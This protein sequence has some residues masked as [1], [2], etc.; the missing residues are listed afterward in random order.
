ELGAWS[1]RQLVRVGVRSTNLFAAELF[2]DEVFGS[3]WPKFDRSVAGRGGRKKFRLHPMPRGRRADAQS[4]A[5]RA[6]VHGLP[7][8]ESGARVEKGTG[9]RS[10]EASGILE[11]IG[12]PAELE[13]LAE[14]RIG[15]VHPVHEPRRFA[16]GE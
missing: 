14:S 16:G 15:G 3:S 8:R 5:C 1:L 10:A 11:N 13:C 12:E 7:R 9:A 2:C 6:R 4:I